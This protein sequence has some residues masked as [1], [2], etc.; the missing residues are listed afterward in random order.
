MLYHINSPSLTVSVSSQ[1]AQLM[2]ILGSDGTEY[3]WQGDARYWGDR[4]LTIF[5]YVARLTGGSYTYR[6]QTYH[7]PIHGFAPTAEFTVCDQAA[8]SVAFCL[9]SSPEFYAMYPFRFRY[10]IRYTLRDDVLTVRSTVQNLDD[11]TMYFGMGGHPGINVPLEKNLGFEDYAL[12]FSPCTPRRVEF[13][14]DCFITGNALPFPLDG[15]RLPL[16]H[17]MFDEDAIVLQDV[18]GP[19]TLRSPSGTHGVTLSAPDYPFYGFW[20]T[21]RTDAPFVCM[22]PWSS[23]P[24]RQD[25]VTDLEQQADL[26]PLEPDH[27]YTADW[28]LHCF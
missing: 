9:T 20:H 5:P 21:P 18:T 4:A 12:E 14:P 24:A 23:L 16:R 25:V 8:D 3:L 7:L 1:G 11:K 13:T 19:V 10:E 2:S 27:T 28:S 17:D 6:G 22:E 15:G 26:I